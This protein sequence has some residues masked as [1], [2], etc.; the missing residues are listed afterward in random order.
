MARY[1]SNE[2]IKPPPV[3]RFFMPQKHKAHASKPL[4][5]KMTE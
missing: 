2:L 4:G 5:G 3:W 1:K